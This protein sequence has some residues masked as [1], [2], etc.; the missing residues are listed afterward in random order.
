MVGGILFGGPLRVQLIFAAIHNNSEY[1]VS[2]FTVSPVFYITRCAHRFVGLI[3]NATANS[4]GNIE[5]KFLLV[6]R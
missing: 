4:L 2:E 3:N 5:N 1:E 6:T